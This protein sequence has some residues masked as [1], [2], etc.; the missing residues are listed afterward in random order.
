MF[1]STTE[2]SQGLVL[3]A[4]DDEFNLLGKM[5]KLLNYLWRIKNPRKKIEKLFL[6]LN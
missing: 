3:V 2:F 1:F 5:F 6:I 4:Q